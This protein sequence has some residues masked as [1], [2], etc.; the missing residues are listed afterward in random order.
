MQVLDYTDTVKR[1][2]SEM[3]G[4]FTESAALNVLHFVVVVLVF[5]SD[6]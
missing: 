4:T 2:A 1:T 3:K 6:R 5:K